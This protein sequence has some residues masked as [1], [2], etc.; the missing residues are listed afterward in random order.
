MAQRKR[1]STKK[2]NTK[3]RATQ[4]RTVKRISAKKRVTKRRVAKRTSVK[5][6]TAKK[7]V[8]KRATPKRKSTKR[9]SRASAR[10][11]KSVENEIKKLY[12]VFKKRGED[13]V[14]DAADEL[15]DKIEELAREGKI[16][17]ARAE[18][19]NDELDQLDD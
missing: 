8:A 12:E 5:R 13:S 10:Y 14:E 16:S 18:R 19:L 9:S 7:R 17:K 4:K 11:G 1:K 3:K 6:R 2:I 15:E